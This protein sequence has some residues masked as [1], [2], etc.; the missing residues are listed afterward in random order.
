MLESDLWWVWCECHICGMYG[1]CMVYSI[2]GVCGMG[3]NL[4]V[5]CGMYDVWYVFV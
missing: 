2:W 1:L 4:Y 5:K 3:E